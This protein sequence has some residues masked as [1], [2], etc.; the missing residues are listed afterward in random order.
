[1]ILKSKK[2]PGVKVHFKDDCYPT[3]SRNSNNALIGII[4]GWHGKFGFLRS[5]S[6][7]GKIF[8]HSK[9]IKE[10][11]DNVGD[12]KRAVFQIIHCQKSVVGAKAVNVIVFDY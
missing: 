12:G 7:S 6:V 10:G 8:L 1:M 5:K 9:D 3:D 2:K 11:R 4:K